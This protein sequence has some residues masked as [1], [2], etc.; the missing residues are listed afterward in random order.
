MN[1]ILSDKDINQKICKY[2][3][4][5]L[6]RAHHIKMQF[7]NSRFGHGLFGPLTVTFQGQTLFWPSTLPKAPQR[8]VLGPGW[9]WVFSFSM[10]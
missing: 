10:F 1:K 3:K 9:N 2:Q 5:N 8:K 7:S 6:Q 4:S